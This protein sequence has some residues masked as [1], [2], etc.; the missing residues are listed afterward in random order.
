MLTMTSKLRETW[1]AFQQNNPQVRIR[2]AA[3]QLGCSEAELVATCCGDSAIRLW[4]DWGELVT[5]LG[6]LGPVMALTRNESA[7]CEKDG[8]YKNIQINGDTGMVLGR[9]IDLRLFL[10][11]WHVGFAVEQE[12]RGRLL[13]SLQF[14]DRA[15]TAVHKVYLREDSDIEAWQLLRD[16]YV[17]PDQRS[18]QDVE[19]PPPEFPEKPDRSVDVESLRAAWR[20]LR[21]THDFR[22]LLTRFSVTRTQALRLAGKD[23]AQRVSTDSL[24]AALDSAAEREAPIMVFVPNSGVIQIHSGPVRNVKV[25]EN[26]INV[27]DEDFNLHVR[28]DLIRSAWVVRKPTVDGIVS[29]LEL[30][31]EAGETIALLFGKRKEGQAATAAWADITDQLAAEHS[32]AE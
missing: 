9:D 32:E 15:G 8:V 7:V 26:W 5:R 20:D 4:A 24:H 10:Q 3:R 17:S 27:L 29:S 19:L 16:E 12:N 31:D 6:E 30:Y 28:G 14:F 11:H 22:H 2:D 21:D 13:R 25:M 23:L 1:Q 18:Q